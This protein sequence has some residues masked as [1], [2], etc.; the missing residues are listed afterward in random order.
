M[1]IDGEKFDGVDKQQVDNAHN[2]HDER[3]PA[4]KESTT[5]PDFHRMMMV[6]DRILV[7]FIFILL[8][9]ILGSGR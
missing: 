9:S 7:K 6:P 5:P 2:G 4:K 3:G 1:A 8:L